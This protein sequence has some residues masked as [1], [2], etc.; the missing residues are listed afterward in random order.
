MPYAWGVASWLRN[1]DVPYEYLMKKCPLF[2]GIVMDP[3]W[4]WEL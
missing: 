4:G 1:A 2:P 3:A